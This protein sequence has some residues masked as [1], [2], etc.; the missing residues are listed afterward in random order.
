MG[1]APALNVSQPPLR[2][3]C[4]CVHQSLHLALPL[5]IVGLHGFLYSFQSQAQRATLGASLWGPYWLKER[6]NKHC[7][8]TEK[9]MPTTNYKYKETLCVGGVEEWN[10]HKAF[11]LVQFSCIQTRSGLLFLALL[12]FVRVTGISRPLF[13]HL[14]YW[15][16]NY[17]CPF[18][19]EGYCIK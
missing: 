5:S 14:L 19:L 3:D 1:E 10:R 12:L 4:I 16:C 8:K 15:I 18:Y 11:W 17:F 13:S 6:Q 9:N 7:W 2:W